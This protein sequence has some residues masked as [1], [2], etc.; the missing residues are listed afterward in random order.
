MEDIVMVKTSRVFNATQFYTNPKTGE[1][2]LKDDYIWKAEK[3]L[4]ESKLVKSFAMIVHDKDIYTKDDEDRHIQHLRE[5]YKKTHDDSE[6]GLANYI[7]QNQY[8][9][10]GKLKP[11]HIHIVITTAPTPTK[12]SRISELLS[13]DDNCIPENC[14]DLPKGRGAYEDCVLYLSH[15]DPK[16]QAKGKHLYNT[17]DVVC[18][19]DYDMFVNQY[20]KDVESGKPRDKKS[21][22]LYEVRIEGKTLNQCCDEEFELYYKNYDKLKK[23]RLEYLKN[24]SPPDYRLN[25]YIYGKG[26]VGKDTLCRVLARQFCPDKKDEEVFYVVGA[27]K[28]SFEGYDGQPIVIWSDRRAGGLISELGRENILNIFDPHPRQNIQNIKYGSVNL[29]NKINIINGQ[30][31]YDT[32]LDA[33]SGEYYSRVTDIRYK[34]EDKN[35]FYR[36]FPL[37]LAVREKDYDLYINKGCFDNTRE[38]RDYTIVK[39]INMNLPYLVNVHP[40]N[41]KEFNEIANKCTKEVIEYAEII[42]AN[43]PSL[44]MDLDES[45]IQK[46]GTYEKKYDSLEEMY[47]DRNKI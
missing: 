32:F 2:L 4:E 14:I 37:I 26:G 30:E 33:L 36:R 43:I 46:M 7:E 16:Q 23:M 17:K 25:I 10:A 38:Y 3:I 18:D 41:S 29:I 45:D 47:T 40:E 1:R 34:A 19:F 31:S 6:D 13:F 44:F 8:I 11:K 22:M 12:L 42:E 21:R 28:V 24:A 15:I 9:L 27:N 5:D 20:Y 39:N 35:Q